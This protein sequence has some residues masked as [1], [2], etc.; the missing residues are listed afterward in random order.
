MFFEMIAS[1]RESID[2]NDD[3]NVFDNIE[4]EDGDETTAVN[5]QLKMQKTEELNDSNCDRTRKKRRL[6][7]MEYSQMLSIAVLH[8]KKLLSDMTFQ[9]IK[10]SRFCD[11][12]TLMGVMLSMLPAHTLKVQNMH[13]RSFLRV[14]MEWFH[15][16]YTT[17]KASDVT[18]EESCT[19]SWKDE[20][21]PLINSVNYLYHF[22][23]P[24]IFLRVTHVHS[25][26][27][28]QM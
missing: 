12:S 17:I 28:H 1:H 21:D 23:E 13:R 24:F 11:D 2:D 9:A 3:E 14:L 10:T 6:S 27:L 22:L 8:H 26:Q 7:T 16:T 25:I 4:W 19:R 20:Q 5:D 18:I 15:S